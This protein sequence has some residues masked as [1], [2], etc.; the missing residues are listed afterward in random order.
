MQYNIF[1]G[2]LHVVDVAG[3]DASGQK[4]SLF[5]SKYVFLKKVLLESIFFFYFFTSYLG[6]EELTSCCLVGFFVSSVEKGYNML[7]NTQWQTR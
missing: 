7:E 1:L 3:A 4:H 6:F 2:I 5:H